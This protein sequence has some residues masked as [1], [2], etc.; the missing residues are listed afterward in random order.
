[1]KYKYLH[2]LEDTIDGVALEQ[3]WELTG[4]ETTH[5]TTNYIMTNTT[6]PVS[7]IQLAAYTVTR[8]ALWEFGNE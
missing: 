3:M 8:D 1:M 7:R 5:A 2:K 6:V 4:G